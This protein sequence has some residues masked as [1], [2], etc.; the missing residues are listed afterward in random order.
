MTHDEIN[1]MCVQDNPEFRAAIAELPATHWSR[2]DL[3][4]VR[5]GYELGR[6]DDAT[7]E[8]LNRL[9]DACHDSDG[10]CYGTL[11]TEFVRDI[12]LDALG[13]VK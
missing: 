2:Y 3:A 9:I 5:L 7:R 13:E 4:A 1:A 8:A 10:A 6:R 12:A 11:S